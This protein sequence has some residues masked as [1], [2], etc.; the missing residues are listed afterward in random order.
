MIQVGKPVSGNE[1]IGREQE[2]REIITYLKI[3][4]SIV[5]I[6]P[7]RFGKT[8]LIL[9]VIRRLKKDKYFTGYIDVF[10]HA[11]LDTI[12]SSI[13]SEVLGN[14]GL[15]KAYVKSKG[16]LL[17]MFKNI[18]LKAVI[19]DFEF[20]L[21]MED[22]EY[23]EWTSFS[24]SID[25]INDF[26][27]KSNK[28]IAF[29]FDEYGDLMKFKK[30]QDIIKLMRSKIQK[31]EYATYLFSGSYKSVMD[32]LFVFNKSPFYRLTRVINLSYLEFNV[33]KKYMKK[34]CLE[35]KVSYNEN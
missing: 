5:V 28:K 25:F 1:F 12:A 9:E 8:S 20:I 2:I 4:Q 10:A 27:R 17:K 23:D 18:K 11:S 29:T 26:S 7:R 3:G 35:F 24:H 6:A 22:N 31:Q 32:S 16:S 34:K 14:H 13:I 19:E 30:A 15:K 21:G 33:L